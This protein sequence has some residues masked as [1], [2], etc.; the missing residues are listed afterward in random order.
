MKEIIYNLFYF[1]EDKYIT[2]I[3]VV[4]HELSGS[5]KDKIAY[6]QSHV[7]SD[8]ADCKKFSI[9]NKYTD[10]SGK[11]RYSD[12]NSM[13]RVG[14]VLNVFEDIFI[15]FNAQKEPLTVSTPVVNGK[16]IYD[17]QA[18]YGS[19]PLSKHQGHPKLGAG[20]M[21]DYLSEY[22]KNGVLDI[23]TLL[24]NDHYIAIK[25]LFNNRNY[26]SAMKLLVSY[27]DTVGYLDNGECKENTFTKWLNDYS[28]LDKLEITADE[29]WEFRNSILHMT[30]LDSRKVV[31]GKIRRISFMVASKNKKTFSDHDV[32]YFNFINLIYVIKEAM[33]KW[34]QLYPSDKE[35]LATFVERYDR[36]VSDNRF[37]KLD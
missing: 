25:L 11:M 24:H 33:M 31:S 10:K 15:K 26:L 6:L 9:P 27:I 18:E 37:S 16:A 19:L 29:L 7:L 4:P 3:G 20:V 21:D 5:D 2:H 28:N 23:S 22:Y 30:N 36:A 13:I 35:K 8:L 32:T 17:I 34:L 14:N 12:F 1:V